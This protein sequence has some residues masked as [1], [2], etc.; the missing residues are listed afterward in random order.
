MA[1]SSIMTCNLEGRLLLFSLFN[2]DKSSRNNSGNR[3]EAT[4]LIICCCLKS[5]CHTPLLKITHIYHFSC[6]GSGIRAWVFCFSVTL[7]ARTLLAGTIVSFEALTGGGSPSK[8]AQWV[9]LGFGSSQAIELK[10][11]VPY[12]L[13]AWGHPLLPA[14]WTVQ[15]SSWGVNRTQQDASDS[16]SNLIM[17][18]ATCLFYLLG[19]SHQGRVITKDLNTRNYR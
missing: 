18:V 6:C 2:N 9:L 19:V 16:L 4:V 13:L 14:P 3:L 17:E 8:M 7:A 1:K 12:W 10:A 5:D 11:S 15:C